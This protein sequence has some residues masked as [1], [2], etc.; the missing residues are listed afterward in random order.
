MAAGSVSIARQGTNH[1]ASL[2]VLLA[3]L[4]AVTVPGAV[5]FTQHS[6]FVLLDAAWSIPVGFALGVGALLLARGA[7]GT[8]SRTLGRSGGGRRIRAAKI[9]AVLGLSLALSAA[10]A[11]GFYELLVRLEG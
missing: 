4:S 2:A 5:V 1:R 6:N 10:I 11:I 3:L 8:L 7:A 9:L